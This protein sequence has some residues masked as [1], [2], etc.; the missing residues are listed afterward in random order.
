LLNPSR[1]LHLASSLFAASLVAALAVACSS[2]SNMPFGNTGGAGGNGSGGSGNGGAGSCWQAETLLD[3]S[4]A[5]GAGQGYAAPTL[6]GHCTDPYFVVTTNGMPHYTFVQTTPNPLKVVEKT[7]EIPLEPAI[8]A[9][10]TKL[11]LLGTAGFAVN[12]MPFFGPNEASQPAESAWGDPVYNGLMDA[13][14][15]HTAEEYHYHS[16]LEKCLVAAGLVAEPWTNADPAANTPSPIIGWALD[17]FP[18]YGPRDCKDASCAEVSVM[19]SSY[20]KTGDPKTNAWDAY[21]FTAHPD[22]PTYLDECN[23]HVGPKGDYHYHVTAGFPY[24]LGCFKGTPNGAGGGIM[25]PDGGMPGDGGMM[26]PKA[27]ASAGDCTVADCPPGSIGCTCGQTPMGMAC[28]P[29]CNTSADCP[30]GPMGM[31]LSCKMG[32]CGP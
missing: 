6:T 29:T 22:D 32:V 18:I 30:M 27:C 23:G 4:K 1:C 20:A 5:P 14:L 2:S 17:G 10:T 24:I 21:T 15:G 26:G 12:G 9:T 31:Q 7:Y 19:L 3:V 25:Q 13:C 16:M 28:I 11:P 8:A